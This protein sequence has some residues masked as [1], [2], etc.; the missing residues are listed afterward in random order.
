M[1]IVDKA[2]V[3]IGHWMAHNDSHITEYD[4]FAKHLEDSGKGASAMHIREMAE[5]TRKAGDC[6]R[7]ALLALENPKP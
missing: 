7:K 6:L 2:A 4:A 5:L 3:R 1:A